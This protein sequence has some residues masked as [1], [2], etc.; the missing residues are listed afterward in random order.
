MAR[1]FVKRAA[2]R[3]GR[4]SARRSKLG[5]ANREVYGK[6]AIARR[7]G[8]NGRVDPAG[9]AVYYRHDSGE[10]IAV[11]PG[12]RDRDFERHLRD[13]NHRDR[14]YVTF[15]DDAAHPA[16]HCAEY[17]RGDTAVTPPLRELQQRVSTA[18]AAHRA[19]THRRDRHPKSR[20][21]EARAA[22]RDAL[23]RLSG[24]SWKA[25]QHPQR[26]RLPSKAARRL[27]AWRG[28]R[29]YRQWFASRFLSR[30]TPSADMWRVLHSR[31]V[32]APGT[33][34]TPLDFV[35]KI[36]W[37]KPQTRYARAI[38]FAGELANYI[39]SSK[40][41]WY[42]DKVLAAQRRHGPFLEPPGDDL[43]DPYPT[44]RRPYIGNPA[45][46]RRYAEW[47]IIRKARLKLRR[48]GCGR[49]VF[50]EQRTRPRCPW[51]PPATVKTLRSLGDALL[52]ESPSRKR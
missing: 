21:R 13:G 47:C 32:P 15:T 36:R 34:F 31:G 24:L 9:P 50:A 52:L 11:V 41:A 22:Y 35:P 37:R 1:R 29:K 44:Y 28:E 23:I 40:G 6:T 7:I 48:C 25:P 8:P 27:K 2:R 49:Y 3:I 46:Q 26:F 45:W 38:G 30:D 12:G 5:V 4:D 14:I 18:K 17:R 39:N 42:R 33:R 10:I 20:V 19:A 51:H 16:T 43:D